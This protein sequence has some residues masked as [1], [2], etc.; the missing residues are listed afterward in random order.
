M[1]EAVEMAS[2]GVIY[3][4]IFMTIGKDVRKILRRIIIHIVRYF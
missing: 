2:T 1:K 3:I 4:S